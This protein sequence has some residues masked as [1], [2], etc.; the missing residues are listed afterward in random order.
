MFAATILPIPYLHLLKNKPYLMALGHLVSYK[1]PEYVAFYKEA[2]ANGQYIILDNGVVE[3]GTPIPID[4]LIKRAQMIG[5]NEIILPDAF[6]DME[7]TLDMTCEAVAYARSHAPHLK[8][9]VVPQGSTFEEWLLCARL[10]LEFD[11]DVI[12]I[13]KVLTKLQ[14]R[15][16]RL[17]ALT[18]LGKLLRGLEIH[19]LGCWESPLECQLIENH[20][21]R[22]LIQPI[23]SV[24]SAIAYV[25]A[26]E[27]LSISHAA[28]PSGEIDFTAHDADI[29]LLN[30][31]IEIWESACVIN[32]DTLR[33]LG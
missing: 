20:V 16:A 26:R 11:I 5:A 14:G 13:P 12:G 21:Q 32:K 10:M 27:G 22:K 28:R 25:Y 18:E 1:H 24:D 3:T 19:L 23:R 9:M 29:E 30:K 4:E 31:N 2:S 7:T 33:I 6:L 8:L 15:D 17:E